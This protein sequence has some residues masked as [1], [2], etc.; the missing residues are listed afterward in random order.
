MQQNYS[1]V[2]FM[3]RTT[4]Y[5]HF[6][7]TM[8]LDTMKKLNTQPIKEFIQKLHSQLEK[9]CSFNDQLKNPVQNSPLPS[10]RQNLWGYSAYVSMRP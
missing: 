9:L 3:T 8:N 2:K 5:T 7:Y 10:N 4:S 6:K 1:N